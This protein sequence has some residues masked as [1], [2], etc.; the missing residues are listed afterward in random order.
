[1][2]TKIGSKLL[3]CLMVFCLV[4]CEPIDYT[5]KEQPRLYYK[6]IEVVVTNVDRRQWF[7]ITHHYVLDI[8]VYS[9]EYGITKTF[10]SQGTGMWRP[11]HW[12]AQKGDTI[13]AILYTWLLDNEQRVV[14]REIHALK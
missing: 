9:E 8:T 4:G 13:T 6:D 3:V 14:R 10:S 12:D 2:A 5:P 7:A 1:M 11:N